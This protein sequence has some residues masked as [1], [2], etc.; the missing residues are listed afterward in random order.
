MYDDLSSLTAKLQM[1][2]VAFQQ[3]DDA[4]TDDTEDDVTVTHESTPVTHS[5]APDNVKSINRLESTNLNN[6]AP[7]S[8]AKHKLAELQAAPVTPVHTSR[9]SSL[10]SGIMESVAQMTRPATSAREENP[11]RLDILF[12]VIGK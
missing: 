2:G 7:V 10:A 8:K 4:Q 1:S 12:A 3:M 5:T 9:G 11:V 6:A